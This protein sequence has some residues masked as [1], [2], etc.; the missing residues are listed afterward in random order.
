MF[1][2]G[3]THDVAKDDYNAVGVLLKWLSYMPK[4]RGATRVHSR[5]ISKRDT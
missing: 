5:S 2:N 3:V 1:N 4:V